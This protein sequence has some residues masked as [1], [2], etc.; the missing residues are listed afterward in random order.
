MR[1]SS[2]RPPKSK[3]TKPPPALRCQG[4]VSLPRTGGLLRRAQTSW[5][6]PNVGERALGMQDPSAARPRS[7][8]VPAGGGL[9]PLRRRE[10]HL[11]YDPH[12]LGPPQHWARS[13]SRLASRRARPLRTV[14]QLLPHTAQAF[15]K[16][17][18]QDAACSVSY[19]S[20]REPV[21]G[22]WR[23]ITSGCR[24]CPGHQDSAKPDGGRAGVA[25]RCGGLPA[26]HTPAPLFLPKVTDPSMARERLVPFP[27][28]RTWVDPL[29][30][31]S[32]PQ[33]AAGSR[34]CGS[35]LGC[36]LERGGYVVPVL[37]TPVG[38]C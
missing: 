7:P 25:P 17:P 8:D 5:R 31:G 35:R 1:R 3:L 13:G 6:S 29:D 21:G 14:H 12:H 9:P 27:G 30:P 36:P 34:S 33:C 22:R 11:V 32:R 16:R 18:A 4:E 37:L 26:H 15:N 23:A 24:T 10:R 20:V 28:H 19:S 38:Y 2:P